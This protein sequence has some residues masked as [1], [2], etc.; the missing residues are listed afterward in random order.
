MQTDPIGYGDGMNM[1]AYVGNDPVNA[2]DPLGLATCKIIIRDGLP[3]AECMKDD[4]LPAGWT[5]R[6]VGGYDAVGRRPFRDNPIGRIIG[7]PGRSIGGGSGGGGGGVNGDGDEGENANCSIG[8]TVAGTLARIAADQGTVAGVVSDILYA[9]GPISLGSTVIGAGAVD[10]LAIG[11][12]VAS[13]RLD[14]LAGN[15]ATLTSRVFQVGAQLVPLA[16]VPS[17]VGRVAARN[18]TA[19]SQRTAVGL[20]LNT[21]QRQ[22]GVFD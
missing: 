21:P 2:T 9:G 17:V 11:L 20:L 3:I 13:L 5:Y 10:A 16:T 22:C 18:N 4:T 7:V 8:Q 6:D 12:D 15:T 19:E 14:H 1:Y